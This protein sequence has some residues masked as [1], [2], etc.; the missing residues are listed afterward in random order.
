MVSQLHSLTL[1]SDCLTSSFRDQEL[2]FTVHDSPDYYK[3]KVSIFNDDKKTELIGEAWIDLTNVVK[4]GGGQSDQWHQLNFK[5]KYAGEIRVE[6]TFYDTREQPQ[7]KRR[8]ERAHST[9]TDSESDLS[10]PASRSLGPREIKRRPL[11]VSPVEAASAAKAPLQPEAPLKR[12]TPVTQQPQPEPVHAPVPVR[13]R[14]RSASPLPMQQTEHDDYSQ[15]QQQDFA[16][17]DFQPHSQQTQRPQPHRVERQQPWQ[18][19]LGSEFRQSQP[20]LSRRYHDSQQYYQDQQP[21]QLPIAVRPTSMYPDEQE[22]WQLQQQPQR[23]RPHAVHFHSDPI[24]PQHDSTANRP[25]P[26]AMNSDTQL[27]RHRHQPSDMSLYENPHTDSPL[28]QSMSQQSEFPYTSQSDVPPPLPPKHRESPTKRQRSEFPPSAYNAPIH[29]PQP[30]RVGQKRSSVS[31][32]SPLQALEDGYDLERHA[33]PQYD[34]PAPQ[35]NN[36]YDDSPHYMSQTPDQQIELYGRRSTHDMPPN[37]SDPQLPRQRPARQPRRSSYEIRH[38]SL[39][40]QDRFTE[41]P[42]SLTS[43]DVYH[44]GQDTDYQPRVEDAPPSPGLQPAVARKAIGDKAKK[45]NN[46]PFGPDAYDV[47]NPASSPVTNDGT[48]YQTPSQAKEAA[49]FREV[50]KLRELGPIIGND[51]REIDPSDH[52]PADTWAPEP[53]RPN[54]PPEHVIHIRSKNNRPSGARAAPLVIHSRGGSTT[55]VQTTTASSPLA[56]SSP[57]ARTTPTSFVGGR[58]RLQKPMPAQA[59]ATAQQPYSSPAVAAASSPALASSPCEISMDDRSLPTKPLHPRRPS[60]DNRVPNHVIRPALS[61]YQVPT[62]NSYTPRQ[63]SYDPYTS[64]TKAIEYKPYDTT[65]T[66]QPAKNY[67]SPYVESERRSSYDNRNHSYERRSSYDNRSDYSYENHVEQYQNE[68]S[69]HQQRQQQPAPQRN[70]YDD[71]LA[72]EMSLID[73]G[74]SRNSYHQGSMGRAMVRKW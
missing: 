18:Q 3:L 20:E 29:I 62:G 61:E 33:Q 69:H 27:V 24:S 58:N 40:Q 56:A 28:R 5:G 26:P 35:R 37:A 19:P 31:D 53:E 65:P 9:P 34:L 2:R 59:R 38:P 22:I 55:T 66:K 30:L 47:L 10:L 43:Q 11:P 44:S 70:Y 72:A 74:P 4:L 71:P 64:S 63:N 32:R 12:P 46:I 1:L 15:I 14:T 39:G 48:A 17:P 42:Q 50:E 45:L 41:E 16:Q 36:R 57:A 23:Q 54:R 49:R 67:S 52:L 7:E 51:G 68:Q 25:T 8:K 73:I 60:Y 21:E 6:L 13:P